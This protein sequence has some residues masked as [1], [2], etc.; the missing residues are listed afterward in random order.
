MLQAH[1]TGP[2][3]RSGMN[4]QSENNNPPPKKK[5]G[6][7]SSADTYKESE[8]ST[9]RLHVLV[10][11]GVKDF[12]VLTGSAVRGVTYT[13]SDPCKNLTGKETTKSISL[14]IV[15]MPN[16]KKKKSYNIKF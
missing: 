13:Y 16:E 4:L 7:R 15:L 14:K 2:E 11:Y 10:Y 6:E 12:I 8:N 1:S 3:F 9:L 5:F